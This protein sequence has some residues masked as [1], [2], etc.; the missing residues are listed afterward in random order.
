MA[1]DLNQKRRVQLNTRPSGFNFEANRAKLNE[2]AEAR[3]IAAEERA[4]AEALAFPT[5]EPDTVKKSFQEK[6]LSFTGGNILGRGLGLGL[7]QAG[8]KQ[9]M[10][11]I[12]QG[13]GEM[14]QKLIAAIQKNKAE[15]KDT[16]RLSEALKALTGGIEQTGNQ[17]NDL[18]T[19]G[20]TNKQVVGDA[21]QLAL[22]AASGYRGG[23]KPGQLSAGKLGTKALAQV[24]VTA[25][26]KTAPAL[27]SGIASQT[28]VLGGIGKGALKGSLSGAGFGAGTGFTQGLKEDKSIGDSLKQAGVGAVT[29]GIAGGVIGGAVGGVS[30]G[31]S[32]YA[33]RKKIIDSQIRDNVRPSLSDKVSSKIVNNPTFEATVKEAKKQGFT[34]SDINFLGTISKQ[35]KPI[36]K[37]MFD[38]TVKAQSDPRQITRAGDILGENVTNQV[39][40]VVTLNKQAGKAVDTA[41]KALRGQEIDV[42]KL[43]QKV[44]NELSDLDIGISAKGKLDFSQSVFKNTPAV[45]KEIQKVITSIPDGSDAYQMHIFK[46]SIDELV[47]YGTAGEGLKGRS[48]NLLKGIRNS[49]DDILDTTFDDY[50]AANTS[51]KQTRDYIDTAKNLVGKK[52]DLG[53]R[54]GSQAFG[55]ALR[56]AFSNNKSRPNTLKFIEDTHLLSKQLGLSG[57]E[58]NLLDQALYVNMLEETFGS[59]AATGLAGEVSK[60][61]SKVQ[62]GIDVVRNPVSGGLNVVADVIEKS[63]NITPEAKKQILKIFLQ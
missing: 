1:I 6:I 48:A 37:K 8:T 51:F 34:D 5:E 2:Q 36:M 44:I 49:A 57:K 40:Q 23:L 13:E 35:D 28:S 11:E 17:A 10:D 53:S 32:K 15:G 20:I 56:S 12:Q 18:Y 43:Q 22:T 55:Q 54:E 4:K 45:Q 7:A 58:K 61:I 41:A 63:R 46:K 9:T 52:V 62:R 39:K 27:V 25:A 26:P 14:Q 42:T 38:L 59:E 50:N 33:S 19:E 24:G 29:G 30:G 16:T 60:A 47:D 3:R 21:A 31:L